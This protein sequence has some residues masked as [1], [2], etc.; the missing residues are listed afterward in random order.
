MKAVVN[1]TPL[2]ALALTGHILLLKSLFDEVFV[3]IS[4][5]EEVTLRGQSRPG[6]SAVKDAHW[7][8]TRTPQQQLPLP[9]E[10]LRLDPG[11]R[12]VILLAKEIEADW[13]LLDEKLARRTASEMGFQV[14]GTLGILL[15]AYR[16]GLISKEEAIETIRILEHSSIHLSQKL[17]EWFEA[18]LI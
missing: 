5:Y 12:D 10:L 17:I 1:S 3:P 11:E 8:V 15:I 13:V 16:T 4:V 6:T 18:Q 9:V 14:K 2:I 7:L